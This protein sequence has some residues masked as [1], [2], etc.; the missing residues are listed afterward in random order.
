MACNNVGVADRVIRVL[1]GIALIVVA[2]VF[3]EPIAYIGIIPLLT[4]LI[5]FCPAY[6]PFKINSG[7]KKQ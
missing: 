7:C 3:S 1:A 4:G 5:G 2:V 6:L